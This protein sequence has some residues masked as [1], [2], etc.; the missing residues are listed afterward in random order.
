M[1]LQNHQE[2]PAIFRAPIGERRLVP[3]GLGVPFRRQPGNILS[4]SLIIMVGRSSLLRG[5]TGSGQPGSMHEKAGPVPHLETTPSSH[6]DLPSALPATPR[7]LVARKSKRTAICSR[8]GDRRRSR[9]P[10]AAKGNGR[11]AVSAAF[12]P[13]SKWPST[14]AAQPGEPS[15]HC[16]RHQTLD[17]LRRRSRAS[18]LKE[19]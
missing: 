13:P 12:I 1:L 10:P 8:S 17:D 11:S 4:M 14:L 19:S 3:A 2:L 7:Q 16:A 18:K 5:I 9:T 6:D 15:Q